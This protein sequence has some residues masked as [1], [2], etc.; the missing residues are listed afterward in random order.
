MCEP[1]VCTS[2]CGDGVLAYDEQCDDGNLVAHDGCSSVCQVEC[3]YSCD[4][5]YGK[6]SPVC[7]SSSMCTTV[8]GDGL[9]AGLESC[10]DGNTLDG[11]GCS[12]SMC[13]IEPGW[14]C[15]SGRDDCISFR[16][17][18]YFVTL[19]GSD[20]FSAETGSRPG[21]GNGPGC[22]PGFT[23]PDCQ[24]CEEDAYTEGC[25]MACSMKA[26]SY[27][28][29][30]VG[31]TGACKC[32]TGWSG[33]DCDT[34]AMY[35]DDL[36]GSQLGS[37]SGSGSGMGGSAGWEGKSDLHESQMA[38][39]TRRS[40][41]SYAYAFK[42][43]DV[44][45]SGCVTQEEA[46]DL[47]GSGKE[48]ITFS[49]ISGGDDC[50]SET[51]FEHLMLFQ[52]VDGDGNGCLSQNEVAVKA[53]PDDVSFVDMAA[54][55]CE[56]AETSVCVEVCGDG[57]RT[58]SEECDDGNTDPNDGCSD[59]CEVECGYDCNNLTPNVCTSECGNG[60]LAYNEQCDDG[61][62]NEL[63]G[64]SSTCQLEEGYECALDACE[65]SVCVEV[66][67]DGVRTRF[68]ECDDGNIDPNDGCSDTCEVECGYDCGV[69]A[70]CTF[71]CEP[72]VCTSECG[73]GVLAYDEQCDD[74]NNNELDGCSS[75][76]QL[77]EGYECALDAC[78]TSVCVEVCGDGVRTSSEACDDGN[79]RS[80]DGCSQ[81]CIVEI[82][83]F[84]VQQVGNL[85]RL[86]WRHPVFS[87]VVDVVI[88]RTDTFATL[89]EIEQ[90]T[91]SATQCVDQKSFLECLYD[92]SFS[93]PSG[94]YAPRYLISLQAV[95]WED[96]DGDA[97][98]SGEIKT[99]LSTLVEN[100]IDVIGYPTS[101]D[102]VSLIVQ[103]EAKWSIKWNQPDMF[104][105]NLDRNTISYGL[106]LSCTGLNLTKNTIDILYTE[107]L[108]QP[109]FRADFYTAWSVSSEGVSMVE[110]SADESNS[111][112]TCLQGSKVSILVHASN[113]LFDGNVSEPF[114]L[115][116]IAIPGPPSFHAVDEIV[117]GFLLQWS[118]VRLGVTV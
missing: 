54:M 115:T 53:F 5:M 15:S 66:C 25:N 88:N 94:P 10:D 6:G 43:L 90:Y 34:P 78:E 85:L 112:A 48:L 74:G 97:G 118:E 41:L 42:D 17:F 84:S 86:R 101:V 96:K 57:V 64:C 32:F 117:V 12:G 107:R 60:V 75:T 30:C 105:A 114:G 22:P 92:T 39:T 111:T 14:S 99:F 21:S 59:T 3:G 102:P 24:P 8:C 116:V 63:D 56:T 13:T 89:P 61:N 58:P 51:D 93:I 77:E 33:T 35:G 73:D 65:T 2:E 98:N 27:K 49:T 110:V 16:A 80:G 76:C 62:N 11:D 71:M 9:L 100:F 81:S 20:L 44:D 67:G 50:I 91:V 40:L 1:D 52:A 108:G 37:G 55:T 82:M 26:C 103:T 79:R 109:V 45:D 18:K 38:R 95:S 72:D 70:E 46:A 31:E 69:W 113:G 87:N 47:Q 36:L 4:V 83:D 28:G 68:E 104:F 7:G 29:R 23:S 19:Y 106:S